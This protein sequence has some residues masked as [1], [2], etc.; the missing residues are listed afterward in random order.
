MG[1]LRQSDAGAS[2]FNS[3]DEVRQEVTMLRVGRIETR[4]SC[5]RN[6]M[7]CGRDQRLDIRTERFYAAALSR[8]EI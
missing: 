7:V 8:T 1:V 2:Q 3:S 4:E 5:D 6:R